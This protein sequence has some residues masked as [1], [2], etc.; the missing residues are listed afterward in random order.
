[1]IRACLLKA[2]LCLC[3]EE[4]MGRIGYLVDSLGLG[5]FW[6]RETLIRI[7]TELVKVFTRLTRED[8]ELL[9][10]YQKSVCNVCFKAKGVLSILNAFRSCETGQQREYRV[11]SSIYNW[12]SP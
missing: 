6:D 10:P 3:L 7:E 5:F 4:Q 12:G 1:M 8:D 2:L 11:R 9:T